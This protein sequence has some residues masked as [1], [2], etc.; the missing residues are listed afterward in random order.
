MCVCVCELDMVFSLV[1]EEGKV[2]VFHLQ[3][4]CNCISFITVREE[5]LV[6]SQARS[7]KI[8]PSEV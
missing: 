4:L 2:L 1:Q 3:M 8:D 5:L 7:E 6:I